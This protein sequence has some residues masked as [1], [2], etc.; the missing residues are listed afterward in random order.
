MEDFVRTATRH[1]A[2]CGQELRLIVRDTHMGAGVK[3]TWLWPACCQELQFL[4][5]D[6]VKTEVVQ[7][8][9]KFSRS[10][11]EIN[12][13]IANGFTAGVNATKSLEF[14]QNKLAVKTMNLRNLRHANKKVRA[15][16]Q[17]VFGKRKRENRIE[18]NSLTRHDPNYAGDIVWEQD[19]ICHS[20]CQSSVAGDGGGSTRSYGHKHRGHQ[21]MYVMNS[22]VTGN[23]V[24]LE[25]NQNKCYSCTVAI[26]KRIRSYEI[27]HDTTVSV[28][29]YANFSMA[30]SGFCS[31]NSTNNPASAEEQQ[32]EDAARDLLLDEHGNYRGDDEAI[33][34][35]EII[36]DNDTR[37]P[38]RAI[39]CQLDI[40]G[41]SVSELAEHTPDLGHVIKDTNNDLYGI[42][43]KNPSFNGKH[44]LSNE[45]IKSIHSDLRK[46]VSEYSLHLGN[47]SARTICLEVCHAIIRH[48]NGDHSLCKHDEYCTYRQVR[49]ANPSSTEED[50][51]LETARQSLRHGGRTMDLS[52]NGVI[53]LE[54]IIKKRFNVNSIDRIA[55]CG[56][57][58]HSE[59]FIG[60][61]TKFSEG[62]RLCLDHS[63]IWKCMVEL[64]FCRAGGDNIERTHDEVS[65]LLG[66]PVTE[67]ERLYQ[68][69]AKK[70]RV[71]DYIRNN[72]KEG[73]RRRIMAALTRAHRMGK[74]SAKTTR[75]INSKVPAAESAKAK[76]K[77]KPKVARKC[78]RCNQPHHTAGI[79]PMPKTT[80]RKAIGLLDWTLGVPPTSKKNTSNKT[81][82]KLL[83]W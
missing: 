48:H 17:S 28:E 53:L 19:G 35:N 40:V 80:K 54:S 13:R 50:V 61:V 32:A 20:T 62:K 72:S 26:N 30:H 39:Q 21:S 79:C 64:A 73:K 66:I 82:A 14:M 69:R 18:H 22:A 44:M 49:S 46:P 36:H 25:H 57:S 33:I 43:T 8:D 27:E 75:H 78:G 37:S 71:T 7:R 2:G 1:A 24:G 42:R 63:D 55:K 81:K 45:R 60:T 5:I 38:K 47:E 70:K 15:S 59:R 4:N 51:R 56:C 16:V 29:E 41:D 9:R 58:N 31:R 52:E 34:F 12:L 6:F 11:P 65:S 10:Q 76:T 67:V 3:E 74:E 23:P 68:K 77:A 83:D